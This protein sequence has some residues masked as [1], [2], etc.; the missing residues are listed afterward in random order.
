MIAR[1]QASALKVLIRAL[2]RL[3]PV[4]S[5]NLGG[6]LARLVGPRLPP[7]RIADVNLRL[8]MPELDR[9]ARRRVVR[10][11]W[12]NLGR[13][14]GELP[15]VSALRRTDAG[16]GW[17]VEGDEIIAELV[18]RGGPAIFFSGHI[19]NWEMLPAIGAAYGIRLSSVYRAAAQPAVDRAIAELRADATGN[20][21]NFP[22]GTAGARAAM[23]HLARGGVLGLLMDQKLN[24][25]VEVPFFDR[26]AMTATSLA[27]LALRFR[28][29][30]IPAYVRRLGPS[31]LRL[32]VESPL[33]LPDTGD[34]RNDM[35]ALTLAVNRTL[36]RWIREQPESWL[37]MHRRWPKALYWR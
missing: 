34:R 5:S 3:G 29:P 7:S 4:R 1:L 36:E 28:C 35:A 9:A 19:G 20:A 24:E 31:R 15:H 6:S 27:A 30:V 12:E 22:K 21:P 13:T 14:V 25:G 18:A 8:A 23:A 10:G 37:W 32:V 2:R 26:P 17:D 33:A 16:P 11:A